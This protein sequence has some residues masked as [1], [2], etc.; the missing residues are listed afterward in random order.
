MEVKNKE[1]KCTMGRMLILQGNNR[2]V[3]KNV[4]LNHLKDCLGNKAYI[5][6][7]R[8]LQVDPK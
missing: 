1:R 2:R 3:R 7:N 6:G 8:T 4:F 5:R